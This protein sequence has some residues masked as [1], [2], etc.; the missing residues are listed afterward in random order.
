MIE[1]QI[2]ATEADE[3]ELTLVELGDAAALTEGQGGGHSEDKRRAYN[4]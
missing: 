2:H 3:D 1:Q 4:S